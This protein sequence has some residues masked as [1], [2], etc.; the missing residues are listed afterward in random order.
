MIKYALIVAG[1]SGS[2]M[3]ST[4]PKQ[5]IKIGSLPI[6]MRTIKAFHKYSQDV[7][8]LVVLPGEQFPLWNE[9]VENHHF[10]IPCKLVKG[11]KSRFASVKNGLLAIEKE[12]LVAIHDGVRPFVTSQLIS[13]CYKSAQKY[14][15]GV[16]AVIPKESIREISDSGNKTVN[17]NQYRL[18]QT[19]QTFELSIIK[20]AYMSTD[21]K[22]FTDDASV[23]D[24]AGNKISL[25]EGDYSNI[26]ITTPEDIK[27]AQALLEKD[28][29]E[30][31]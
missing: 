15:S 31:N 29:D 17:R 3:Q 19:P 25:V 11:G 9:L 23:A 2:R 12:G 6:L 8:I 7:I 4:T 27:I 13:Q 10:D 20:Q 14:G 21:D 30:S 26:K 22:G 18:I 5:F 24:F 1:G 28:F 16:A